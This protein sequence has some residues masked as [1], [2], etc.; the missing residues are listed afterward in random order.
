M[1]AQALTYACIFTLSAPAPSLHPRPHSNPHP[2]SS[3]HLPPY[4]GGVCS[5]SQVGI[6][7]GP[8]A[9]AAADFSSPPHRSA[10]L[11]GPSWRQ[12]RAVF[13]N[14]AHLCLASAACCL[15]AVVGCAC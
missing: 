11:A 1:A 3:P 10:C 8:L 15:E 6:Y 14:G 2:R 4:Y 5:Y 13:R 9:G 7:R 12:H